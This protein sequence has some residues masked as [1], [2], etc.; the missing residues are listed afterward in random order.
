MNDQITKI[1]LGQQCVSLE[2]FLRY[3]HYEI[4]GYQRDYAW[5]KDNFNDLVE[6]IKISLKRKT[7]HFFGVVMTMPKA[8]GSDIRLV[9]DGQQR[10]TTSLVYL[11]AIHHVIISNKLDDRNI[12]ECNALLNST[13]VIFN[14][15]NLYDVSITVK[16][17][18]KISGHNEK[19]FDM[20][21][22]ADC[23]SPKIDSWF[24]KKKSNE[25]PETTVKLYK[26][27]RYFC[28]H[29]EE[30]R[31]SEKSGNFY[32]K[33]LEE[34]NFFIRNFKVLLIPIQSQVFAYQ[35]FQ[36][37]N[38]RGRDLVVSDIIKAYFHEL[39]MGNA[40]SEKAIEEIW[41]NIVDNL[42]SSATD[43]FLRHYW[44]SKY[45]VVKV[46]DLL[47]EIKI[48][49]DNFKKAKNFLKGLEEES[50]NYKILLNLE[51]NQKDLDEEL[52]DIFLLAKNFVMP[53]LLAAYKVFKGEKLVKFVSIIATFVFRYRTI[54]HLENKNMERTLSQI[55]VKIRTNKDKL[56]LTEIISELKKIDVRDED[57]TTIF[58]A[59]SSRTNSLSKYVLEKIE[60][61]MRG[62][63]K[64]KKPWDP[65]MSVEH[66][67]P[68]KYSQNWTD[69]LTDKS[70]DP[71]EFIHRLGN[72]TLLTTALNS[73]LQNSFFDQKKKE[74][75]KHDNYFINKFII[76]M[77]EWNDEAINNRQ[78]EFAGIANRIWNLDNF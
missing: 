52:K 36:T 28:N 3:H 18:L 75:K 21:M 55:A 62:D 46:A 60:L 11:K 41:D 40:E 63:K 49:Y 51:T 32:V 17:R 64:G 68:K 13:S 37:V 48:R 10:I 43:T 73:G 76:D 8:D 54:C 6:D 34:V 58:E 2:E 31:K 59:F 30:I 25:W 45:E 33:A 47:N 23:E 24:Q 57:F 69:Y 42:G 22:S 65:K 78:K 50:E 67:L 5:E 70:F 12:P 27:F 14:H 16:P 71:D 7:Q 53:P 39:C 56:E 4:P 9:I 35:F 20:I 74:I 15:N 26:S 72:L 44:L 66:V 61:S 38:D 1:E 19:L 77:K 29:F